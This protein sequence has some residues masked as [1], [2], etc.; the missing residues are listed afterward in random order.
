MYVPFGRVR[1]IDSLLGFFGCRRLRGSSDFALSA[2]G[3]PPSSAPIPVPFEGAIL[4][5]ATSLRRGPGLL[6]RDSTNCVREI[7]E[8]ISDASIA[9]VRVL[10]LG[11]GVPGVRPGVASIRVSGS[12]EG[13]VQEHVVHIRE[14]TVRSHES[15]REHPESLEDVRVRLPTQN[16]AQAPTRMDSRCVRSRDFDR[17][18]HTPRDAHL[19]LYAATHRIAA[20][21][22]LLEV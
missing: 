6:A 9:T 16:Q 14:T 12:V 13:T 2:S 15:V 18:A 17:L 19:L 5:T 22:P 8:T 10:P 21:R 3:D 20:C 1:R 7:T 4:L 11:V